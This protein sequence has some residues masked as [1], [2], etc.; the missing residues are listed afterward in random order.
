M[1]RLCIVRHREYGELALRREAEALRD[2]GHEVHVI[3]LREAGSERTGEVDGVRV[4]ALP[5][6][7]VRGSKLRYVGDYLAFFVLTAVLLAVFQR[8]YRFAVVQ[9]NTMPDFLVLCS[10][11]AK[12]MGAKVIA[13]MKEPTPELGEMKLGP[14]PWPW[15]LIR[16]EQAVLRYADLGITVTE[17]LKQTFV[18]R[19]ADPDRIRVVLNG[20]GAAQFPALSASGPDDAPDGGGTAGGSTE[21]SFTLLCHGA[22]EDRYGH[23]IV[24]RAVARART[25]LPGLRFRVT[26]EGPRL[27]ELRELTRQLG[28]EEHVEL[29]GWVSLEDL[30]EELRS[31]DVGVVAQRSSPYSNLVHTNKMYEYILFGKPVIATRLDS[32]SSYFPPDSIRYVEPDDVESMAEAIVELARRPERRDELVRNSRALYEEY[33]WERQAELL[34][35]AHRELA[36]S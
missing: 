7:R 35:A 2:A 6:S 10:F 18:R 21:D 1:S 13:F 36:A 14:G 15:L 16:I 11:P 9:V 27:E 20:P 24:L 26:G 30:S 25:E 5:L 29:L 28:L 19:G 3:C 32:I 22:V 17:E 23:D 31:A 4:H 33:R 12:L 8:R 34:V